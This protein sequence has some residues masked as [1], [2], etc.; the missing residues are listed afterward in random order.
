VS[1]GESLRRYGRVFDDVAEAYDAVRSGYPDELVDAALEIGGL[2]DGSHVVEVGCG[3]GKLTEL[4][5]ARGL[6]VEAVDPGANM[7]AVA[8]RRVGDS[9]G[10]RFHISTFEDVDLPEGAFD[11]VFSA[12][13]FHW[14]DPAIGWRKAASLLRPGGLLALLTHL[15]VSE[16]ETAESDAALI[17]ALRRH[18]PE[19]AASFKEPRSARE[20][21]DGARERAANVSEAWTWIGVHHD[22]SVPEAGT[23]FEGVEVRGL[24]LFRELTADELIALFRTTSLHARLAPDVRDALEA[25]D[26]R[27]VEDFGGTIGTSAVVVLVTARRSA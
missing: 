9:D 25:D 21:L 5:V 14:I 24:P 15:G 7:V 4:L 3:T 17:D 22:L 18:A 23:L 26:R 19:I 1:A 16:E 27:V 10:A 8:A 11:A 20:V 6:R 2:A 13:A 12:T